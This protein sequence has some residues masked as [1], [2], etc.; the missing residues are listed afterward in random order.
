MFDELCTLVLA[1]RYLAL[2]VFQGFF[3]GRCF[4][5]LL[6]VRKISQEYH[7]SIYRMAQMPINGADGMIFMLCL[8]MGVL[9]NLRIQEW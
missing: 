9:P 6:H 4:R 2:D 1:I 3:G 5:S 7:R 8:K